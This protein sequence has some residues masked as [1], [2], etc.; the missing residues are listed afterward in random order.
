MT[1]QL[2]EG[3]KVK[4]GRKS[5]KIKPQV[6]AKPGSA[7][8]HYTLRKERT[9]S[10]LSYYTDIERLCRLESLS[11]AARAKELKIYFKK[12]K[13]KYFKH[14]HVLHLLYE[15]VKAKIDISRAV[16]LSQ[17]ANLL[18]SSK[19]ILR[20]QELSKL[21]YSLHLF[22]DKTPGVIHLLHVVR[23]KVQSCSKRISFQELCSAMYGLQGF[24]ANDLTTPVLQSLYNG[25]VIYK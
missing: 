22:I 17:L 14:T 1:L 5:K 24:T 8:Y 2:N 10:D 3:A 7:S 15:A 9:A 16:P 6:N 11:S 12:Q 18:Q 13:K 20:A 4:P 19:H 25:I 23:V 21:L